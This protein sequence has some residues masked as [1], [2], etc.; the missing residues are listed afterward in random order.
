MKRYMRACSVRAA[1]KLMQAENLSTTSADDYWFRLPGKRLAS[2]ISASAR[3]RARWNHVTPGPVW[4]L[5]LTR[6]QNTPLIPS[7]RMPASSASANT[8]PE[9]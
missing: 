3:A 8:V 6:A 5:L 9:S 1:G 2:R 4:D 7:R